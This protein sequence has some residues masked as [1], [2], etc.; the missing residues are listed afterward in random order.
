MNK[1]NR[2]LLTFMMAVSSIGLGSCDILG[3]LSD[4]A[5]VSS[6][7]NNASASQQISGIT[8]NIAANSC[9][10]SDYETILEKLKKVGFKNFKLTFLGDIIIGL[11]AK[12]NHIESIRINN[13][14]DFKKDSRFD[15]KSVVFMEIHSKKKSSLNITEPIDG[16]LPILY[17]SNELDGEDKLVS[18][19]TLTDI[20][21][22]NV[23]YN[24]ITDCLTTYSLYLND[25][26]GFTVG[27]DTS[28]NDYAFFEMNAPIRISYHTVEGDYCTNGLEHTIVDS[29]AVEPTCTEP[30]WTSGRCCSVCNK[31]VSGHMEIEPKGHTIVV[32][33]TG[34]EATCVSPG[35]GDEAHCSVC[36]AILSEQVE[37]PIDPNHH[38]NIEIDPGVKA[39]CVSTGI[40][41]RVVCHDCNR[42]VSDHEE[43]PIDPNNHEHVVD[44]EEVRPNNGYNG[45]TAYSHCEDCNMVLTQST[46]IP[47]SG[48]P[49]EATATAELESS[50]PKALAKKAVL[51]AMC[52][53]FSTDVLDATGNYVV[54]S[55]LHSYSYAKTKYSIVAAGT[56]KWAGEQKWR[57]QG[58]TIHGSEWN[59]DYPLYGFI[60]VDSTRFHLSSVNNGK[61]NNKSQYIT[62]NDNTCFNFVKSLVNA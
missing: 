27:G 62:Y 57:F 4:S 42:V 22:T 44:D 47:W 10:G 45:H 1:L 38:V 9:E 18:G 48:S 34:F 23:A 24:P 20:G 13:D 58:F 11:L 31:A 5:E 3:F 39:T 26:E 15:A 40:S 8:P 54:E 36:N 35:L 60:S 32:D 43:L 51:T 12:E 25:T 28:F 16:Q 55:K 33:K 37:L 2:A 29:P 19:Q 56:W 14:E 53:Y 6:G 17:T 41:D 21:F 7:N 52:N 59:M 46:S 49:E 61:S 30:G 50:F